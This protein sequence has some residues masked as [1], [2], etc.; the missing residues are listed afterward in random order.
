MKSKY[1]TVLL[2]VLFVV[3]ILLFSFFI[4]ES[5]KT[6]EIKE[7]KYIVEEVVEPQDIVPDE[8]ME[9][10]T[11]EDSEK[12][13]E[14]LNKVEIEI[15]NF[16]FYPQ[17]ITISPGTTVTWINKDNVPHKIVAFDRLFYG[18]RLNSG[19]EY[20][21]IFTN[22]GTHRYFDGVFTKTGR[23]TIIV[24][25]EPLPITGKVTADLGGEKSR[26]AL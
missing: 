26:F 23:G 2:M 11:I 21:F 24:K 22:E 10:P 18:P 19:D 20:A 1:P 5:L 3:L 12:E 16:G 7:K 8:T 14:V 13:I 25:K 6:E 9:S 15:K 17:E 4:Y